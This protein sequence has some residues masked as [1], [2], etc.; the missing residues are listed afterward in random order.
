[1]QSPTVITT[2]HGTISE[3]SQGLEDN[4][5]SASPRHKDGGDAHGDAEEDVCPSESLA[6]PVISPH[7]PSVSQETRE[8]ASMDIC[9]DMLH[10]K[11][12]SMPPP[13]VSDE[14]GLERLSNWS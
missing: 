10:T 11:I 1:M 12:I 6:K 8:D 5:R 14:Q 13:E 9:H 3:V 7:P 4:R 2:A